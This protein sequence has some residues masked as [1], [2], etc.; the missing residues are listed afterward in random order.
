[1]IDS[2]EIVCQICGNDIDEVDVVYC[3]N[4]STPHHKDCWS[5]TNKCSTYGCG[6]TAAVLHKADCSLTPS[7][8]KERP[9]EKYID[10]KSKPSVD[11][12]PQTPLTLK[13]KL[14]GNPG[15]VCTF[16]LI[17]VQFLASGI[18]L[19]FGDFLIITIFN[20]ILCWYLYKRFVPGDTSSKLKEDKNTKELKAKGAEEHFDDNDLPRL[21]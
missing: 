3:K 4:C 11:S 21:K 14:E 9:G 1:M 6:S 12:M 5:Y 16:A 8:S 7:I 13:N 15:V 17:F 2:N 18:S 19:P 20:V 10:G